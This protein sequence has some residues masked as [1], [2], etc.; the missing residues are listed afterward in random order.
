MRISS[1]EDHR[2]HDGYDGNYA[3]GLD[4]EEDAFDDDDD[5]DGE[6]ENCFYNDEKRMLVRLR[7]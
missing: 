3:A 4:A 2:D 1:Y 6:C 7:F 5:D